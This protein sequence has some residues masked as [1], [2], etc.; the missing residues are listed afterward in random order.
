MEDKDY[1]S[2][3]YKLALKARNK[4]EVP[5]GAVIVKNGKIISKTYNLRQHKKISTAHAEILAINKACKKLKDFRLTGCTIFVTLEPCL[6]CMG[7]ILNAR[8]DRLVFGAKNNKE[9]VISCYEL[10]ERAGLN[11][12]IKIEQ[13]DE[14]DKCGT[15][16]SNYFAKKRKK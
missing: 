6:M 16:I 7:A 13:L 15:L 14:N 1:M 4:D 3:A 11:H 2:L 12:N 10:A 9:D 5:V 8:I